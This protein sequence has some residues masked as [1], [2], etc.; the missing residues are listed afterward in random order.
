LEGD[1]TQIDN[2]YERYQKLSDFIG[3]PEDGANFG[4]NIDKLLLVM[5]PLRSRHNGE[6]HLELLD[7]ISNYLVSK[8]QKTLRFTEKNKTSKAPYSTANFPIY[9][10]IDYLPDHIERYSVEQYLQLQFI[11]IAIELRYLD[12]YKPLTS[13]TASI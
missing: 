11:R 10:E 3:I 4:R 12:K 1:S 6:I 13:K 5:E 2:L 7:S 9:K 8:E